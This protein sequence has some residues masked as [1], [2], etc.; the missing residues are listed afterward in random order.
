MTTLQQLGIDRMSVAERL[1]LA[2]LI[3]ESVAEEQPQPS[4]SERKCRELDRRLALLQ[5][6][7]TE[8]G[9]VAA[10]TLSLS[11]LQVNWTWKMKILLTR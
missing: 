10:L 7:S 2:H 8:H 4:L 5:Q 6:I 9:K 1:S 3:L 11:L